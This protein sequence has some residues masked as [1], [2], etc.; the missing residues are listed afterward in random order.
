M[1]QKVSLVSLALLLA[2]TSVDAGARVSRSRYA[3]SKKISSGLVS[4]YNDKI[5]VNPSITLIEK[6]S[7][8]LAP[9]INVGENG[10]GK[11]TRKADG[12]EPYYKLCIPCAN[13]FLE[14]TLADGSFKSLTA[15]GNCYSLEPGATYT[16]ATAD[17]AINT[18]GSKLRMTINDMRSAA[19]TEVDSVVLNILPNSSAYDYT[20]IKLGQDTL[21]TDLINDYNDAKREA[22]EA[23]TSSNIMETLDII[24]GWMIASVSG[25]GTASVT[26]AADTTFQTI[27]T[28][29]E[30]VKKDTKVVG[31]GVLQ[32]TLS[33]VSATGNTLSMAGAIVSAVEL[34]KLVSS[35]DNC[36][37]AAQKMNNAGVALEYGLSDLMSADESNVQTST[38]TQTEE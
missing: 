34:D 27:E 18:C 32:G 36:K 16:I 31:N 29:N 4:G 21:M 10:I 13:I 5:F 33:A 19:K 7:I 3:S 25:S 1:K 14:A 12:T 15:N 28:V 35:L 8:E 24:K 6:R 11:I 37:K 22:I 20:N 38:E 2:F 9:L 23:C 17:G 30:T 26:G